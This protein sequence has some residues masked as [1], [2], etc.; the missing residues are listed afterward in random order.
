MLRMAL[1]V[2]LFLFLLPLVAY[3]IWWTSQSHADNWA[4]A[5]WSSAGLLPAAQAEQGASV[6][7]FAAPTG[8]WKGVFAVHCWIVLKDAGGAKYTRYD[9]AGWAQPI[10]VDNWAADGRWYGNSPVIV[11][12]LTGSDAARVIPKLKRA[13]AAY[14]AR[15]PGDY[16][17][18]PGP[19]SNSF[20]ATILAEVP[21]IGIALPPNAVGRDWRGAFGLYAG[22]SP[23]RTG[24]QVSVFGLLGLTIGRVE[25]IE[26]NLLGLVAGFDWQHPGLKLPGWGTVP[27]LRR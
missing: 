25:G 1:N 10:K 7:V 18:W 21:E 24:V 9:V 20:I 27:L 14:P 2:F 15:K 19:N 17:L 26:L 12:R 13:I 11:G 4:T 8:R 22:Q 5:D 16:R 3:G 23:S 6:T